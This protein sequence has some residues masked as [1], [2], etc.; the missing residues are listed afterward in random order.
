[1]KTLEEIV[2]LMTSENYKDRF[3]AEY[4]QTKI[5]YEKLKVITTKWEAI[6]RSNC[7]PNIYEKELKE[8]LGFIPVTPLDIL[9]E[10]QSMMGKYLHCLELRAVL[11]HIDLN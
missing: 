3:V 5:R 4:W 8:T 1:M 9:L 11:E 10:Q 6:N 7:H 2:K